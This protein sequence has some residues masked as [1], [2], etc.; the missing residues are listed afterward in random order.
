MTEKNQVS[1]SVRLSEEE[2]DALEK[3]AEKVGH[4]A[5]ATGVIMQAIKD[6]INKHK[7]G[8][9][10][11]VQKVES[12]ARHFLKVDSDDV[13]QGVYR[14]NSSAYSKLPAGWRVSTCDCDNPDAH[15]GEKIQPKST[16]QKRSSASSG[17]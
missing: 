2:R 10:Q 1:F 11:I 8:S 13:V 12:G 7:S 14:S 4:G 16:I 3:I 5:T 17:T 9:I 15:L 6:M